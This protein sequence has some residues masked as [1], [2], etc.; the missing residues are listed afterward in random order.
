MKI[1]VK[2]LSL[3]RNKKVSTVPYRFIYFF[4]ALI[5]ESLLYSKNLPKIADQQ[6]D[7]VVQILKTAVLLLI[8][9]YNCTNNNT[10]YACIRINAG[11]IWIGKHQC[12]ACH[13]LHL[14]IINIKDKSLLYIYIYISIEFYKII[15]RWVLQ[16]NRIGLSV[17]EFH[18]HNG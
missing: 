12:L 17:V 10:T 16:D 3:H 5:M 14:Y 9:L 7:N 4:I 1:I 18:C 13:F 6:N 15:H 11:L 8:V 2:I